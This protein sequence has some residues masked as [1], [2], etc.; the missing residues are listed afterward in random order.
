MAG[1]LSILVLISALVYLSRAERANSA[2]GWGQAARGDAPAIKIGLSEAG[3]Y[4]LSSDELRQVGWRGDLDHPENI[5]L[6]NQGY[7]QPFTIDR[8]SETLAIMF[9]GQ[10]ARGL[11][12]SENVYILQDLD[13]TPR[14]G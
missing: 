7:T 6:S 2:P 13:A 9:Y 1:L 10:P 12:S 14:P 4:R 3:I 8:S 11:Y 5:R